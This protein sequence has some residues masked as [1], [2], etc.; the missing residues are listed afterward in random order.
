MMYCRVINSHIRDHMGLLEI[1]G[2]LKSIRSLLLVQMRM[3]D[4]NC[5]SILSFYVLM[6]MIYPH[7]QYLKP[8]FEKK[9]SFSMHITHKNNQQDCKY[10]FS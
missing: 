9:L 8:L 3:L 5:V 10:L 1:K 6:V 7:Y 4:I 2:Y